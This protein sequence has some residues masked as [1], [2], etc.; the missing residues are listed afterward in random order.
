ML[1]YKS[2]AKQ[3]RSLFLLKFYNILFKKSAN[4]VDWHPNLIP[5][6]AASFVCKKLSG[7]CDFV[8]IAKF[9]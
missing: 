3:T 5:E 1:S 2:K 6:D 7:S 4:I 8:L 9:A